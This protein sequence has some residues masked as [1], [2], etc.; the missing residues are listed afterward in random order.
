MSN[1]LIGIEG[2]VAA[3]KTTI[4]RSLV[5]R[6]ENSIFIDTGIIYRAIVY[7]IKKLK[8]NVDLTSDTAEL[9][10][11]LEIEFKI[12]QSQTVIYYK[13]NKLDESILQEE[14]NS[15]LLSKT[16]NKTD[17]TNLYRFAKKMIDEYLTKYNVILSSRG[18]NLFCP[19][20]DYHFYI[21]CDLEERV[22]R[23]YNQFCGRMDRDKIRENILIRD[24]L[25]D[26]TG[27]ND[28][29]ENTIKVDVTNCK[30]SDEAVE[31]ILRE[32]IGEIK[33]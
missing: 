2:D 26:K 12:E 28:L 6:I 23:R 4:C 16:A 9:L 21:T 30:N 32:Y 10:K 14:D 25:H 18:I 29:N 15:M 17:N 19:N 31:I 33:R 27:F 7:A 11:K 20:I 13:K 1:I 5:K 24:E 3:G 22:N 8:Q